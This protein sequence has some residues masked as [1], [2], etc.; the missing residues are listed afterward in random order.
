MVTVPDMEAGI[1][2]RYT[3]LADQ[4]G[5][6]IEAAPDGAW[7]NPSPCAGWTAKDIIAHVVGGQENVIRAITGEG[8][9]ADVEANPKEAWR[10][11]YSAMTAA[12]RRPGALETMTPSPVGDMTVAELVGRFLSNDVLVH[13][14]DLARTVGG[15]ETLDAA[16]VTEAFTGLKPLDEMLRQPGIFDPKVEPAPDADEQEQ[17]LNFLGRTTRP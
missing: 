12:L 9:A 11:S 10:A 3:S 1:V 13:T 6:R 16:A 17:F 4:F 2:D 8:V 7:S 15:D 5:A 14:W